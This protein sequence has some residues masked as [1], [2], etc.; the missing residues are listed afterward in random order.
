MNI[1]FPLYALRS[2]YS[3]EIE[4][5]YKVISTFKNRYI[6]DDANPMYGTTYEQRRLRLLS[7]NTPYKL[8]P[9]NIRME[10]LSHILTLRPRKMIDAV[11]SV[12][13]LPKDA[14]FHKV[15]SEFIESKYQTPSGNI[16]F[17][18]RGCPQPFTVRN[19]LG[20]RYA[21]YI[22]IG[23]LYILFDISEDKLPDTRVKL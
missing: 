20:A 7:E 16:V 10:T 12:V 4:G 22:K 13:S 11:G 8:Y 6:L 1:R 2:Y 9:L 21:R 3:I 15:I 19:F 14:K 5:D 23:R 17:N 18:V